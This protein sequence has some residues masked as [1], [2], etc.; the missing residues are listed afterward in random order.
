MSQRAPRPPAHRSHRR[1]RSARRSCAGA[2]PRAPPVAHAVLPPG[3]RGPAPRS[4][5]PRP[6]PGIVRER[7]PGGTTCR[8][9]V[10][11]S[12][13]RAPARRARPC[14]SPLPWPCGRRR[15]DGWSAGRGVDR[16][17]PCRAGRRGPASR[18]ARPRRQ[19]RPRPIQDA[20]RHPHRSRPRL[21]PTR[22]RGSHEGA[23]PPTADCSGSPRGAGRATRCRHAR[24]TARARHP[25]EPVRPGGRLRGRD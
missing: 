16:H 21:P 17:C 6:R 22:R 1:P 18:R 14:D 20:F 24:P 25:R 8:V 4:C 2:R 11:P 5:R 9:R 23:C 13:H 3:D 19:P 10:P 15:P 7:S 12:R